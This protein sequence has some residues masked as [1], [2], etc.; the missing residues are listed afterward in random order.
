[1]SAR[2]LDLRAMRRGQST[3]ESMLA[4]TAIMLVL[5]LLA[6]FNLDALLGVVYEVS[7]KV[8]EMD[9]FDRAVELLGG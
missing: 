2:R 8:Q 1:M 9:W 4:F 5:L 7:L 6:W 3:V